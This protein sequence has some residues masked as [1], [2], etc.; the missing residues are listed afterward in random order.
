MQTL[1]FLISEWEEIEK[2]QTLAECE[3]EPYGTSALFSSTARYFEDLSHSYQKIK[4]L[5]DSLPS[6]NAWDPEI[7]RNHT[8]SNCSSP[9]RFS[10]IKKIPFPT[11]GDQ[12]SKDATWFIWSNTIVI[13]YANNKNNL[14]SPIAETENELASPVAMTKSYTS[15]TPC[16]QMWVLPSVFS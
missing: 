9:T 12:M 1:I 7:S 10:R 13:S 15:G 4:T 2:Y 3:N 8:A 14:G 16:V 5:L 6:G 11:L